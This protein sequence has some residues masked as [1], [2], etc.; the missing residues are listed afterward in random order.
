MRVNGVALVTFVAGVLVL[1]ATVPTGAEFEDLGIPVT[2]AGLMGYI[3]GPDEH[4]ETTKL[5]FN[6]NQDGA[7]L[8]LVQVDPQ[9]GEARQFNAPKGPG[10]WAFI[11]GP[12]KKIYLGTWGGG[13]I[14]RFD[15]ARLDEGIQVVGRPS[16]T[17]TYI[18]MYTIGKDGKLYGCTYPNAKLISYEPRTGKMADLGRM[19]P[20][21]QY[22]RFVA[23]GKNGWIYTGIGFARGSIVA[24]NPQTGERRLAIPHE[25]IIQG[26]GKVWNGADGHAYGKLGRHTYR[27]LDGKAV[28]IAADEAASG[29]PQ[30]LKDGRIL[31]SATLEGRYTL[32]D[33]ATRENVT[34][35][36]EY[37]G[38]GSAV[39][40]VGEGPDGVIYGSTA[41]PLELFWY[42]PR[43]GQLANPGN[44]CGV[45]GEIYSFAHMGGKLYLCAYPGSWLSI[46]DPDKPWDYGTTPDKNPY[47]FGRIGDGHL[48]PR[49]MLVGS[50]GRLYIGSLPP[51]GQLGGALGIYDPR[52]NKVVENYRNLIPNQSIVA[53]VQ[54]PRA[55]QRPDLRRK[56]RSGRRRVPPDRNGRASFRVGP[57]QEGKGGG[58]RSDSRPRLG[59]FHRAGA[60]EGLRYLKRGHAGGVRRGRRQGR[61]PGEV[62]HQADIALGRAREISLGLWKD[63]LIYGLTSQCIFTIDPGTYE[64]KQFARPDRPINCGWAITDTGI[65][66][67]SG[68]H[69]MRWKW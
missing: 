56:Q 15:P 42:D 2:K 3:V 12:D 43:S 13:L 58:H 20:T 47:G 14:L 36:F 1:T 48:R 67:G 44:P 23:T 54:E 66:F 10:A 30:V 19:D 32:Y 22:A 31:K 38:A 24:Y 49:A 53:L 9:T 28:E 18:W 64:I 61:S 5:Y 41:M 68:V 69:L 33:P 57:C 29:P 62:V 6:F 46:Y 16:E 35:T 63:G 4:G 8:F 21:E 34:K 25:H 26:C 27:L 40:V 7:P 37:R 11:V 52:E 60:W 55:D 51:Y 65:Y 17:E 45:G 59:D 39:F 50:D